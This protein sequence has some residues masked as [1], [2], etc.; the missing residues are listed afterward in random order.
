MDSGSVTRKVKLGGMIAVPLSAALLA[1]AAVAFACVPQASIRLSTPAGPVGTTINVTG[2]SFTEGATVSV[3]W[4]GISGQ[5]M[6][7]TTAIA[8]G[9]IPTVSFKVP[10]GAV[11][12]N[13][14][15]SAKQVKD[16]TA[17]GSPAN[18][19]F[20]VNTPGGPVPVTPSNVQDDPRSTDGAA[21]LAPAPAAQPAAAA[22]P[23]PA[24]AAAP[25]AATPRVRTA[26]PARTPAARTPAQA[27][28][29]AAPVTPAPVATP[30]PAVEA[31]PAPA[32][33]PAPVVAPTP[34]SAPATSPARRSVMVSMGSEDNGSPALAIALVGIGLV[35]ALGAS[36]VVLAGRRDRKAPAKASR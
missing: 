16:G 12:G 36:A 5:L 25:V 20:N 28:A 11:N 8:G 6:G 17:I 26:T 4:D 35:L 21:A 14:I 22:A 24:P 9:T 19:L 18:V 10:A 1:F 15:V 29:P 31:T 2:S 34:E 3:Y 30:A 32:A 23:T 27:A 13:T 33:T 7:S